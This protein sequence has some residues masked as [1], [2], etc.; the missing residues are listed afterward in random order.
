MSIYTK[1][2][3]NIYFLNDKNIASSMNDIGVLSNAIPS[4]N[5]VSA[6]YDEFESLCANANLSIGNLCS[7][8]DNV[9]VN[10][11][12]VSSELIADK[13]ELCA[14]LSTYSNE[15]CTS[16]SNC[17]KNTGFAKYD[18]T[19]FAYDET[20]HVISLTLKDNLGNE[21]LLSID[22]IDFIKNRIVDHM[23]IVDV[24][25]PNYGYDPPIGKVLRMY[26]ADAT[27]AL[28]HTDIQ[29]SDFAQLYT[30]G[31]GIIITDD[32]VLSIDTAVVAQVSALNG[33]ASTLN[34]L[35]SITVP[36]LEEQINTATVFAGQIQFDKYD[37]DWILSYPDNKLS[38]VFKYLNLDDVVTNSIKNGNM[39]EV[40]F[41]DNTYSLSDTTYAADQSYTTSDGFVLAHKDWLYVALDTDDAYV[42]LSVLNSTTVKII[43]AVSFFKHN[44]LSNTIHNNYFWLSG[45]NNDSATYQIS[46]YNNNG[47]PELCSTVGHSIGGNNHF[48]DGNNEFDGSNY[49]E[50]LST[51]TLS[52]D[53]LLVLSDGVVIG[54]LSANNVYA[55]NLETISNSI[56]TKIWIKDPS[57]AE[58]SDG[59]YSDLSIQKINIAD[60][61]T[62]V[63]S[64]QTD[65]R[66]IYV[67]SA[68]YIEAYGQVI[69]NMIMTVDA[70]ESEA[71]SQHYVDAE[72]TGKIDTVNSAISGNLAAFNTTG[73]LYDSSLPVSSMLIL[74]NLGQIAQ[75]TYLPTI[76]LKNKTPGLTLYA[77]EIWVETNE[78]GE[79]YLVVGSKA[80]IDPTPLSGAFTGT[81]D[82]NLNDYR[83][84]SLST[85][86]ISGDVV[87]LDQTALN[88][89][90]SGTLSCNKLIVTGTG[91]ITNG[92]YYC[93]V[94]LYDSA[95][96]VG[97]TIMPGYTLY[98]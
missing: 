40:V 5:I 57:V 11:F 7:E 17:V 26:W 14:T 75:M 9:T 3:N 25:D 23:E 38:S 59:A 6:A 43:P 10:L 96:M 63:L 94:Y 89:P 50:Q 15:L 93:D 97:G 73:N 37:P 47:T 30:D 19:T 20:A 82:G 80:R 66:T 21:N 90:S 16:L 56:S 24:G 69:S 46:V 18:T 12:A 49:I 1:D 28:E 45:G 64:N 29:V 39:Y 51:I 8:I 71:A 84:Y 42:P 78:F 54:N 68:D 31:L 35:S 70:V 36:A 74:D 88:S 91:V 22:T 65:P 53:N 81:I 2:S 98:T 67:V 95:S 41:S 48:L 4:F 92:T 83:N 72:L 52:T 85:A 55:N 58:L 34:T 13:I 77:H 32:L 27:G 86:P 61:K 79:D 87:L 33:V 62:L 76:Q 60:Y 44:Q